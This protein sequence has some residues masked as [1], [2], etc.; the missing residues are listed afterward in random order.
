[1][2]KL[3]NN[4]TWQRYFGFFSRNIQPLHPHGPLQTTTEL[5]TMKLS[6][7]FLWQTQWINQTFEVSVDFLLFGIWGA[8]PDGP[9]YGLQCSV[10]LINSPH[11]VPL[12]DITGSHKEEAVKRSIFLQA[13][14]KTA[15]ISPSPLSFLVLQSAKVFATYWVPQA[16]WV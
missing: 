3:E 9:S 7:C 15:N 12:T 11:S 13:E 1:M 5:T 14:N 6:G 8:T 10:L 16:G 4:R 2:R